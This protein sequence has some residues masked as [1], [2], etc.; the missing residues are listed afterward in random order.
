FKKFH[1]ELVSAESPLQTRNADLGKINAALLYYQAKVDEAYSGFMPKVG[2]AGTFAQNINSYKSGITNSTNAQ[3]WM[4]SLGVEVPLFEGFRTSNEVSEARINL[5]K[6]EEEKKLLQDAI[7][8]QIKEV[9]QRIKTSEENVDNTMQAK[10]TAAENR[11]LNERA[12][13]QEMAEAKDL[14][15]AQIMESIME[16]QYLK[17]LYDHAEAE[18]YLNF[19]TGNEAYLN[20]PMV[21]K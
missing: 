16:V 15:E 10:L 8:L 4:V 6:A 11:S 3:M 12:F 18:A 13:Q 2:I 5:N 14:I 19:L 20:E 7:D 17:S 21:E 9:R 1:T